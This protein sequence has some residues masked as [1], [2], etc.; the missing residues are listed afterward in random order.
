MMCW[1]AALGRASFFLDTSKFYDLCL[2]VKRMVILCGPLFAELVRFGD[3]RYAKP[4]QMN[5]EQWT[6]RYVVALRFVC[7]RF[8]GVQPR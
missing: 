2:L 1:I 7:V 3:R 8:L 6:A 4:G 5:T